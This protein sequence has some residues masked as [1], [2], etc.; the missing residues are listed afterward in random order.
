MVE[1]LEQITEQAIRNPRQLDTALA[2]VEMAEAALNHAKGLSSPAREAVLTSL[3]GVLQTH[4]T[5]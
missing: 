5:T 2:A 3:Q 4:I 1:I